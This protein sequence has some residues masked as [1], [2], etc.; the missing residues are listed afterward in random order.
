MGMCNEVE[1]LDL[2]IHQ[3]KK[4]ETDMESELT[5][6]QRVYEKTK[7]DQQALAQGKR[8]LVTNRQ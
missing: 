4:W 2:L 8:F 3:M 6:N 1:A 5:I 7:K